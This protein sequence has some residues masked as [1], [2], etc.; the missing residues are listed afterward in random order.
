MNKSIIDRAIKLLEEA[1][2]NGGGE[3]TL[4]RIA[5]VQGILETVSAILEE[6]IQTVTAQKPIAP[7]TRPSGAKINTEPPIPTKS[8]GGFIQ[9]TGDYSPFPLNEPN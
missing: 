8:S 7:I 4:N 2:E 1:T 5:Q 3:I 9:E 6:P